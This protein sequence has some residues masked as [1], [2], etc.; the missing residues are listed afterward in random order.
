M[1]YILNEDV[2]L[3]DSS[4]E[5]EYESIECSCDE[6]TDLSSK[7]FETSSEESEWTSSE[8]STDESDIEV[9]PPSKRPRQ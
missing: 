4:S 9:E 2:K 1:S 7:E 3:S 6:S 5:D 8:Y